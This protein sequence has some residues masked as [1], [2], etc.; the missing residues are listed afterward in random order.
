[1]G[2]NLSAFPVTAQ[3]IVLSYLNV[4]NAK[5]LMSTNKYLL[6]QIRQNQRFWIRRAKILFEKD[7][8]LFIRLR[9][10]ELFPRPAL[11]RHVCAADTLLQSTVRRIS[12]G[13]A[14]EEVFECADKVECIALDEKACIL[15][16]H[17][18]NYRTL[19][20]D[21]LRFRDPPLRII[22]A[23][24]IEEVVVHGDILFFRATADPEVYHADVLNWRANLPM[25][26]LEPRQE[27][28]QPFL[29]KSDNFLAVYDH[30]ANCARAYPLFTN[31]YEKDSIPVLFPNGT[32]LKDMAVTEDLIMAIF[33]FRGSSN[34]V[35]K[36]FKIG[37][38]AIIQQFHID[39]QEPLLPVRIF[40]PYII[41]VRRPSI[42]RL[43]RMHG[44][45]EIYGSRILIPGDDR[46]V[47]GQQE[48]LASGVIESPTNGTAAQFLFL[49]DFYNEHTI[50]CHVGANGGSLRRTDRAPFCWP[51]NAILSFGLSVI[52][53]RQREIIFRRYA[54]DVDIVMK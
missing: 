16:V 14:V 48:I 36:S 31:G 19:I 20:F 51:P 45:Y 24:N 21:L 11:V 42:D 15:L 41:L 18:H 26:S 6:T 43:A 23:L 52:Y 46:R 28:I 33:R 54:R 29:S 30:R 13:D 27:Y 32:A 44:V 22:D 7:P 25:A 17:L 53:T 5:Y 10:P 37:S 8:A 40:F 47:L 9:E 35:F 4:S 1:M 38:N 3:D 50:I 2:N 49:Q 39:V 34:H 12:N